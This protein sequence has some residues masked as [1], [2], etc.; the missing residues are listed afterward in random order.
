MKQDEEDKDKANTARIIAW[1]DKHRVAA[2]NLMNNVGKCVLRTTWLELPEDL[3]A[4]E[5]KSKNTQVVDKS[6]Q[7]LG[8]IDSMT[9]MS[10]ASCTLTRSKLLV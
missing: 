2:C 8:K 7:K 10:N 5:L 9:N 1:V 4:R 3:A 6:I